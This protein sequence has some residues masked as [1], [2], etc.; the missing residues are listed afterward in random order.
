MFKI[1]MRGDPAAAVWGPSREPTASPASGSPAAETQS[2]DF[3]P[4][5]RASRFTPCPVGPAHESRLATPPASVVWW[6]WP[7]R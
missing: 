4:T 5:D 3:L 2:R 1:L 7:P 6:Q